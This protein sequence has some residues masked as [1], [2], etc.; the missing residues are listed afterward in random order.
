MIAFQDKV[1]NTMKKDPLFRQPLLELELTR[2]EMRELA[3][4]QVK[5]LIEYQFL[6][7]E[8]MMANPV[9]IGEFA[10]LVGA[11][12]WSVGAKYALHMQSIFIFF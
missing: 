8:E 9:L 5:R 6:T 2:E 11:Y 10:N 4:R 7:N 3:F 1:W 12:D